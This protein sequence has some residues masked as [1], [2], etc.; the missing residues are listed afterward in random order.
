LKEAKGNWMIGGHSRYWKENHDEIYDENN[1]EQKR[2]INEEN[3]ALSDQL[4]VVIDNFLMTSELL[5]DK[6][7]FPWH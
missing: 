4:F 3:R 5:M 1:A 2:R 7:K 6:R